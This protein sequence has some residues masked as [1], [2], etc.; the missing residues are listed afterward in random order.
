MRWGAGGMGDTTT[1]QRRGNYGLEDPDL[2]SMAGE[3]SPNIMFCQTKAKRVQTAPD[4]CKWVQMGARGCI[5][6]GEQENK[7]KRGKNRRSGYI[8]QVW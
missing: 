2:G 4:G 8:L 7:E 5:R 3:I 6:T 1:R